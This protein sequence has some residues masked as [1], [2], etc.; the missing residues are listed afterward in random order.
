MMNEEWIVRDLSSHFNF[1]MSKSSP[2]CEWLIFFEIDKGG[3]ILS[4]GGAFCLGGVLIL[5]VCFVTFMRKREKQ[6]VVICKLSW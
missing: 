3:E 1:D 4:L 2:L 6:Y 5:S